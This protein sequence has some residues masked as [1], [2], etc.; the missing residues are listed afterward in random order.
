MEQSFS[1][2]DKEVRRVHDKRKRRV[3]K[4]FYIQ[5]IYR[6][7]I[8]TDPILK[9]FTEDQMFRMLYDIGT[10]LVE[11]ILQG[12]VVHLPYKMGDLYIAGDNTVLNYDKEK[13]QVSGLKINWYETKK[14]WYENP[15]ARENHQ[16]IKFKPC[17]F[18]S[19]KYKKGV[20]VNSRIYK[21]VLM[22]PVKKRLRDAVFNNELKIAYEYKF[23]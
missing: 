8:K 4:V 14:F 3:F 9:G 20:F 19:I 21:L 22:R 6:D 5:Q 18:F 13:K 2:F 12:T 23:S 17:K 15:G 1:D 16:V 11:L 7:L 10:E